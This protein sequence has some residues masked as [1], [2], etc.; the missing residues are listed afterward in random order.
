[1]N[2]IKVETLTRSYGDFIAV[3]RVS[4]EI[5][6]GEIVGLLGHNG[7]GKTT[8]MKMLTGYLEP[9]EGRIEIDGL[10]IRTDREAIQRKIGYLP[11]NC[12]VYPEMTVIDYL[13]YAAELHGVPESERANRVHEAIRKTELEPKATHPISILSRGYRQRTGVA[14]AILHHPNILILDEPTNGLDPTQIQHM[15]DLIRALSKE[16]TVILSTHILQEVQA[17]CDR[18]LIVR[19]GELALD[20]S[21][22][23]LRSGNRLLV[24]VDTAPEK[25]RPILKN[26]QGVES[27][28]DL[29]RDGA[30][31]RYALALGQNADEAAPMVSRALIDQG[32]KLYTLQRER[33]DLETVFGEISSGHQVQLQAAGGASHV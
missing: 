5:K 31:Y 19:N 27:V 32:C 11:E 33:R 12:P 29:S 1:V 15:R 8:I 30:H 28:E 6:P 3:D 25:A 7:A 26:I 10:D 24:A 14:Q 22:K 21:M 9:S 18:V 2:V 4:F 23:E 17:I 20:T 16:A 13:E